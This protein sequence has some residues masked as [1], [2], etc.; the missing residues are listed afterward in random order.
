MG[1]RMTEELLSLVTQL[2]R[3]AFD[4]RSRELTAD[5]AAEMIDDCARLAARAGGEMDRCVR[6]GDQPLGPA[7]Q[8][9]LGS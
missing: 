9:A 3:T 4:L 2:E 1:A 7:G 8:L 6:I 5:E